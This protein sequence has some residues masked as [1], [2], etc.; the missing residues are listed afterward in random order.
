MTNETNY[1]HHASEADRYRSEVGGYR[2]A[3]RSAQALHSAHLPDPD[4]LPALITISVGD[5]SLSISP[6]VGDREAVSIPVG[7]VH[8]LHIWCTHTRVNFHDALVAFSCL[9]LAAVGRDGETAADDVAMGAYSLDRG[10]PAG[11]PIRALIG[12]RVVIGEGA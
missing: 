12:A 9:A 10:A 2:N 7:A 1:S 6:I 3:P 11:A 4:P 5:R 8:S